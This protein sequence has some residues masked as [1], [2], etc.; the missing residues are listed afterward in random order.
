[1]CIHKRQLLRQHTIRN[2]LF[3]RMSHV[4]PGR[5]RDSFATNKNPALG[6]TRPEGFV[7]PPS[8]ATP[9]TRSGLKECVLTLRRDNGR[10]RRTLLVRSPLSVVRCRSRLTTDYGL[11]TNYVQARLRGVFG[12]GPRG[13]LTLFA[14]RWRVALRPYLSPSSPLQGRIPYTYRQCQSVARRSCLSYQRAGGLEA[15]HEVALEI[16]RD[17]FFEHYVSIVAD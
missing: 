15:R 7:V 4:A 14:A 11:Q 6:R 3:R 10:T 13:C 9:L 1:M 2:S 8:F 5:G 12:R 17:Q 16:D